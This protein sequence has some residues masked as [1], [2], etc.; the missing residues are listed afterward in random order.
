MRK[1]D[2]TKMKANNKAGFPPDNKDSREKRC[3]TKKKSFVTDRD[4]AGV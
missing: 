3:V 4:P 1:D 2:N